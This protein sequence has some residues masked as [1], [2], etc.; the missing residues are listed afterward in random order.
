MNWHGGLK[1]GLKGKICFLAGRRCFQHG[2]WDI[3]P[4]CLFFQI[5]CKALFFIC[6]FTCCW[7][8][9][10][11]H[12]QHEFSQRSNSSLGWS[13]QQSWSLQRVLSLLGHWRQKGD[14]LYRF[15][16]LLNLLSPGHY[17]RSREHL[18]DLND[19]QTN[20]WFDLGFR[21]ARNANCFYSTSYL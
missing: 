17:A 20:G 16:F 19:K 14:V 8:V 9:S 7:S 10:D 4:K 1:E 3:L 18:F 21:N 15:C 13:A 2:T 12:M 11:F 6:P 5:M